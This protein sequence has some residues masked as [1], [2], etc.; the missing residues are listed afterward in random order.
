MKWKGAEEAGFDFFLVLNYILFTSRI[1]LILS[2][3]FVV[4]KHALNV[5]FMFL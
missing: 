1:L 5:K 4:F 2:C 3:C